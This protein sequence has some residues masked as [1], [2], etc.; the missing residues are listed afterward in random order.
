MRVSFSVARVVTRAFERFPLKLLRLPFE[1]EIVEEL[2]PLPHGM[3]SGLVA[4]CIPRC[5]FIAR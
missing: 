3:R 1:N 2:L 4:A 5:S